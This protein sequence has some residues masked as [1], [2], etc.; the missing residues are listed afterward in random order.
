[1]AVAL[2]GLN[3][4]V[5]VYGIGGVHNEPLVLLCAVGAVALAVRGRAEDAGWRWDAAAGGCVLLAAGFKP[6]AAVLAP[7]VVLGC[8]RRGVA[9]AGAAAATAVVAAAALLAYGPHLPAAGSRTAWSHRSAFPTC[10][11]RWP[12]RAG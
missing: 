10:S 4:L 3:P 12:D 8:R 2:V 11:P 7:V 5:L 6:S 1:M 9:A